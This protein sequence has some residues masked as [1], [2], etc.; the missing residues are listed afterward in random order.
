M[1]K[2]ENIWGL[3]SVNRLKMGQV[4]NDL[5]EAQPLCSPVNMREKLIQPDNK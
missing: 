3:N 1:N 5:P 2:S 4:V